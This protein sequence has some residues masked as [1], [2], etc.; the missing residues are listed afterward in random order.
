MGNAVLKRRSKREKQTPGPTIPK[1]MRAAVVEEFRQP[2]QIG[3]VSVPSP[4][5][6][7][8]LVQIIA[9]GLMSQTLSKIFKKTATS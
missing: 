5:P 1:T 9:T 3:E 7:Q 8:A 4:G 6:G 2:L